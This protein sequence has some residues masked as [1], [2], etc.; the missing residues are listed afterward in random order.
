MLAREEDV[1]LEVVH[2]GREALGEVPATSLG[3]GGERWV[4][5]G[6]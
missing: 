6:V 1:G 3:L 4:E 5:I 2:E